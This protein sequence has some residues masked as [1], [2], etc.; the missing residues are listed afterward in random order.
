MLNHASSYHPSTA[1]A[2]L[3]VRSV[4]EVLD[5]LPLGDRLLA[6]RSLAGLVGTRRARTV[7]EARRGGMTW[8]E[9]ADRLGMSRQAVWRRF[10]PEE[11]DVPLAGALGSPVRAYSSCASYKAVTTPPPRSLADDPQPDRRRL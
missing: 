6:L 7:L 4:M 1:R 11:V 9:I 8:A 3:A 5:A 10:G 2:D